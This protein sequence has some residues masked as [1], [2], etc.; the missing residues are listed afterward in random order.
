MKKKL[1]GKTKSKDSFFQS[2]SFETVNG[3]RT[4][5]FNAGDNNRRYAL[6]RGAFV[7]LKVCIF[8]I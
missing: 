6:D 8:E 5:R 7:R 4:V 1:F 3:I 2:N